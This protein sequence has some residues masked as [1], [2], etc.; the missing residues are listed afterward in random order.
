MIQ[1]GGGDIIFKYDSGRV[2]LIQS[3]NRGH[4]LTFMIGGV[5]AGVLEAE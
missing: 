2:N 5:N 4:G 1:G 3:V